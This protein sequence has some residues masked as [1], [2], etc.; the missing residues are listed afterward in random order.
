MKLN[1]APRRRWRIDRARQGRNHGPY[2][3]FKRVL[4]RKRPQILTCP[5]T[6]MT[7][8][9]ASRRSDMQQCMEDKLATTNVQPPGRGCSDHGQEICQVGS[10]VDHAD[11]HAGRGRFRRA[12]DIRVLWSSRTVRV[13]A[14]RGM[15]PIRSRR[16]RTRSLTQGRHYTATPRRHPCWAPGRMLGAPLADSLAAHTR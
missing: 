15:P 7:R 5:C 13:K 8:F 16:T 11:A 4:G 10:R 9:A 12:R 3:G 14:T 6:T 2:D 1:L